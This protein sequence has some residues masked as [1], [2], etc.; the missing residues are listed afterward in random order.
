M[1]YRLT[2]DVRF[3]NQAK[4]DLMT[5]CHFDDWNPSH[6]LDIAEMSFAVSIGYD[7]LYSE[8][9]PEERG[10]IKEALLKK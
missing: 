10:I 8:L 9:T 1:A 3:L 4:S 2:K 7:W 6:F 5:V